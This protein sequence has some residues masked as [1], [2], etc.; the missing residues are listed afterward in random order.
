MELLDGTPKLL[1]LELQNSI[2]KDLELKL[3]VGSLERNLNTMLNHISMMMKEVM[4]EEF[5]RQGC[6]DIEWMAWLMQM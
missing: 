5:L 2:S 1:D 6:L 3:I 4:T